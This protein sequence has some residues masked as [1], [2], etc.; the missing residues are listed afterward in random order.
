MFKR[1]KQQSKPEETVPP[2]A[3]N[4]APAVQLRGGFSDRNNIEKLSDQIQLTDFD[5]R[6]RTAINNLM[7]EALSQLGDRMTY[8]EKQQALFVRMLQ[9]VFSVEITASK[10]GNYDVD[11]LYKKY[12][13]VNFRE[14]SY[15]SVLTL[16][17]YIVLQVFKYS[18]GHHYHSALNYKNNVNRLFEREF[19]GYRFVDNEIAPIT[20]KNEISEIE[21][22]VNSKF[23]PCSEHLK[24]ALGFLADREKKDYKNSIKESIS[25][26]EAICQIITNDKKATLGC[27]IKKL[28]DSKVQ[29]HP[30]LETAFSKLY[31]Y[32]TDEG[33]IRHAA[34]FGDGNVTFNEAK[35]MLV[36]CSAFVNYLIYEYSK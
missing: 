2:R 1:K 36:S 25:S 17:E 18:S 16:V 10:Y 24:K 9:D 3:R 4:N 35:F 31:G 29:I 8:G 5:A 28:K 11:E 22:A 19:V 15:H 32:T 12:I 7:R 27:A 21:Q 13:A 14:G 6:T 33:G 34:G 30:A 23:A 26:V 20:D